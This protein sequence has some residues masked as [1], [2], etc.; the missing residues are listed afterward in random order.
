MPTRWPGSKGWAWK[1]LSGSA[2]T[3]SN[4]LLVTSLVSVKVGDV[5]TVS[6]V[7]S[8][9]KDFTAG[10]NYKVMVEDAV[11]AKP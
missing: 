10:Y 11:L 7:V 2:A 5:I 6:G 1:T 3:Q 8:T 9:D 4:D